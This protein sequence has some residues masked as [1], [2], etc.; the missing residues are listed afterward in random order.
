[1]ALFELFNKGNLMRISKSLVL[2]ASVL[3][4]AL[5]Q[6]AE[7]DQI[8]VTATRAEKPLSQIGQSITIISQD[9]ITARQS[10]TV[11]DLL[12]TVPGVT[13]TRNGGVGAAVG[14][15][16]G[17]GK[18]ANRCPHRWGKAERS[19]HSRQR[20]QLRRSAHRQYRANRNRERVAI[21]TLGQSGH[22]RRHKHDHAGAHRKTLVQC[23]RRIWVARHGTDRDR[24]STRLN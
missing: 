24:K 18:R 19:V 13:F 5:A 20:L 15:H 14:L 6:A 22:W 23:S 21:R 1:M 16:Q 7:G 11:V 9:E 8:V 3:A 10:V 17:R 2:A 4:P 12:R